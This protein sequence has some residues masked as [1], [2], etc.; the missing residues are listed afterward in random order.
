MTINMEINGSTS[1]LMD[2]MDVDNEIWS[3][4]DMYFETHFTK[5]LKD[6]WNLEIWEFE[7]IIKHK[8]PEKFI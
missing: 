5:F 7:E 3:H 8:F 1:Q 6:K 4:M 2:R